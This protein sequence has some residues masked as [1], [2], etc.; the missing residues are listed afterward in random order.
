MLPYFFLGTSPQLITGPTSVLSYMTGSLVPEQWNGAPVEKATPLY[1]Q[2]AFLIAFLAGLIQ[3][4]LGVLRL[5]FLFNLVSSSVI[6]GFTTAAAFVIAATQFSN[7]LG[8]SDCKLPSGE[9][10]AFVDQV[11]NVADRIDGVNWHVILAGACCVGLLLL[12]K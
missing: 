5:G 12:F 4:L 9:S 10:C 8:I 11:V 6:V 1:D 2:L 7:L 3:V